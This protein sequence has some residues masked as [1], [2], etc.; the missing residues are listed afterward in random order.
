MTTLIALE[1]ISVNFGQ[2]QVLSNVSLSLE[3]GRILTLLGP[4]GAGKSTLVRVVLG[5]TAPT[6]GIVQRPVQLR[7]GYVPQKIHLDATLPLS[8]GRFMQ[9]RPGVKRSDILPALKR[10]QAAHLLEF[11]LQKL[12]GGEMQRVL[13]ARALLNQ[14]QLLV[15]DEPTQGVDVN[16]QVALYDLIDQLRRELNCGVLM[17]SHDLHLVMAKTDEV[18]CLNHHICCSGT[19]EAVSQHPEFISMFGSRGAEQL[20]IYR[21]NHN[22]R[23]DLQGR[24]ILRRGLT[25]HD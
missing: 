16:G 4:N 2:R 8:V 13:L 9:L 22:H 10:V 24:I 1:K 3:P 23:H 12:S 21:H 25:R 5:L 7:I 18:L 19:P 14:P 15:L 20:A 11:P 6:S 17:V